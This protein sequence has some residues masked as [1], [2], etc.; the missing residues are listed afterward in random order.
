VIKAG[1]RKLSIYPVILIFLAAGGSLSASG[2]KED[3][4]ATA[5]NLIQERRYNEALLILTDIARKDPERIDE[6]EELIRQVRTIRGAYY[7]RYEDLI[8]VLYEDRDVAKA[9]QLIDDLESLDSNPNPETV[10]ALNRAREMAQFIYD[11]EQFIIIMNDALV[12]LDQKDYWGAASRY[13]GAFGMGKLSFDAA[14]YPDDV[15][16][17]IESL[18]EAVRRETAD[19]VD[20]RAEQR[21]ALTELQASLEPEGEAVF[22]EA[23]SRYLT[24]FRAVAETINT[25]LRTVTALREQNAIISPNKEDLYLG[26]TQRF[27]GG[28]Q[29][30]ESPEGIKGA[31]ERLLREAS[32][33]VITVLQDRAAVLLEQGRV[34]AEN[35]DWGGALANLAD[36]RRITG[37]AF[38]LME[39]WYGALPLKSGALSQESWKVAGQEIPLFLSLRTIGNAAR[40]SVELIS[41][42]RLTGQGAPPDTLP[43]LQ[44]FRENLV[45]ISGSINS[46]Q[47]EWQIFSE[48]TGENPLAPETAGAAARTQRNS[49]DTWSGR[50]ADLELRTVDKMAAGELAPI[51]EGLIAGREEYRQGM[52]FIEGVERQIEISP[53]VRETLQVRY[54]AEGLALFGQLTARLNSLEPTA[55]E[56]LNVYENEDVRF[57]SYPGIAQKIQTGQADLAEIQRLRNL[58]ASA[59]TRAQASI[60]QAERYRNEG[61]MRLAETQNAIN[62]SNFDAAKTALAAARQS[63]SNSLSI[64]ESQPLRTETDGRLQALAA[65]LLEAENRLVIAEVYALT[66]QGKTLYNEGRY[67]EAENVLVRA[68]VR[69]QT[70]QIGEDSEIAYWLGFVRAA[71]LVSSAREILVTD[72]LYNEMSQLLNLARQ[73][74]N[75][76]QELVS[77]GNRRDALTQLTRADEKLAQVKKTFPFN[78]AASVLTLRIAFLRDPGDTTEMFRTMFNAAR[79]KIV[80]GNRQGS[81][82][83][84]NELRDLQQINPNFP[85][86]S[87]VIFEAEIAAGLRERP[88]DQRAVA[89]SGRLYQQASAIVA[90]NDRAQF[91][92]ALE[93]LNRAL[94]LN[95]NNQAAAALRPR[96]QEGLGGTVTNVLSSAAE[97]QFR[98]AV[99]HFT[100]RN[101]LEAL[102]IVERLLQTTE[103][104][105]YPPLLDLRRRI[106]SQI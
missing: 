90:R 32:E 3:P 73:D 93:Q 92:I 100:N 87:A 16:E 57:R 54:P 53:E 14:N 15:R 44:A 23:V 69:W 60:L 106:E 78:Q 98:L 46:L 34:S 1:R 84:L 37:D 97:E 10:T 7:D 18:I 105:N 51:D 13:L 19:F 82:E 56:F 102:A 22:N 27:I 95:P 99:Q 43:E 11:Q 4:V 42:L 21:G 52:E 41:R 28:R 36:S 62:A 40:I 89:E 12:L 59:S 68:Q 76:A 88:P 103:N 81:L 67:E 58:A 72:P 2:T 50:V 64:Q 74:Y 104:R 96:V 31:A 24:V 66:E 26:Y 85:G 38:R 63:F 55:R 9:L 35:R 5:R 86:M 91:P 17:G 101:F 47:K 29:N 49:L 79:V 30:A 20:A 48:T 61:M 80:P 25:A 77:R 6:A 75:Q 39:L 33:P 94:R 70:T 8:R 45:E 65:T 83:A 71:L